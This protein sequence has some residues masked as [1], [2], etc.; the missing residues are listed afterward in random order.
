[1]HDWFCSMKDGD[2]IMQGKTVYLLFT[3]T[4]S[5]LTK[6]IKL[7]TKQ[8]LNH[9]SISFDRDLNEV[10]SFGRKRQWNPLIGGFVREDVRKGIFKGVD[11]AIYSCE[12]TEEEFNRMQ[13]MVACLN[14]YKDYYRYNF[15][16]LFAVALNIQLK[17]KNAYFCS[18]FVADV[19]QLMRQNPITKPSNLVRP[20][21]I[22]EIPSLTLIYKGKLSTYVSQEQQIETNKIKPIAGFIMRRSIGTASAFFSFLKL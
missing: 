13:E 15:I 4:G 8:P 21:D 7:Y 1:M 17:R 14:K 12:V 5:L 3:D 11:C 16:G 6:M 22:M 19:L 2:F 9:V 20:Q 10:Y 18:Q